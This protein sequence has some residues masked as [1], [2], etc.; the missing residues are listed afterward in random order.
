MSNTDFHLAA[1]RLKKQLRQAGYRRAAMN[2]EVAIR[3]NG[4][5]ITK[6]APGERILVRGALPVEAPAGTLV[7]I[8]AKTGELICDEFQVVTMKPARDPRS[9]RKMANRTVRMPDDLVA[10][11]QAHRPGENFGA[12]VRDI[13]AAHLKAA[14]VMS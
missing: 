12:I 8:D 13:L 14:G 2:L 9:D 4:L 1:I 5:P 3:H 10:A 6:V 7:A 11:L